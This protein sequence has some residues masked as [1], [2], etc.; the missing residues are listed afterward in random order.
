MENAPGCS[1]AVGLWLE[2]T[3]SRG[4]EYRVGD[5]G[6]CHAQQ[7]RCPRAHSRKEPNARRRELELLR[8]ADSRVAL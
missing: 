7:E 2:S 6:Y 1:Q 3:A 5:S 4:W 8:H